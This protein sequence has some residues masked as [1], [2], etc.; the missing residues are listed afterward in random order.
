MIAPPVFLVDIGQYLPNSP[1]DNESIEA[2]LGMVNGRPSR[3]RRLTLRNNGIRLRHY[4]ID[5]ASG[6][7]TH[8]NAQ[9]TAQAVR[10]G[11]SRCGWQ[12]QQVDLLV[13]G[14]S[15]PDQLMPGHANMVHAELGGPRLEAVTTAGVCAAGA[16]ALKH[17]WL[18]I[19]AGVARRAVSTGSELASSFMLARHF[20]AE[21]DADIDLAQRRPELAFEQDFLRWMLSDGAGAAMLSSEPGPGR[22]NLRIDAIDGFSLANE[23]PVCMFSGAIRDHA[24]RL[25]G[26]RQADNPADLSRLNYFSIKQDA[27]I[28]LEHIPRLV[29]R[30]TLG[31]FAA[32][33]RIGPDDIAWFLPHQSS[34]FFEPVLADAM[35]A[36][37]FAIAPSRW[38]TNLESIGNIGSASIYL[39]LAELL[40]GSRLTKGDRILCFVPESARFSVYFM[41]LTVV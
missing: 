23:L 33:H 13:C 2:V 25:Q 5:P 30:D 34:A 22:V 39:M 19:R 28:L 11:L 16:T 9:L 35:Q 3:A 4:A 10:D 1:I 18:S 29:A 27:R 24:G 21:S 12:A 17:A 8:T 40:H 37:G 14:T 7:Q 41:L 31:A 26:W 6:R 32:R 20:S 38:F 36:S 15:S